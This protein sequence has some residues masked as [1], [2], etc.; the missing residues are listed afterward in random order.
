MPSEVFVPSE[1]AT[2]QE[3]I[4]AVDAGGTVNVAAGLYSPTATIMANKSVSILGP[5]ANVDPRPNCM[6][7]RIPGD[8]ATEAIV[9]GTLFNLAR[10]FRITADDVTING[11]EIRNGTGDLVDAPDAAPTKLRPNV[12]YNIIHGAADEGVQLRRIVEG[13]ISYNHIYDTAGDGINICCSSDNNTISY[14]E[15]HAI[16]STDAG[17]ALYQATNS[18]I[19]YNIL[20]DMTAMVSN[21]GIKLGDDTGVDENLPGGIIR[22]NI[23]Y[24]INEDGIVVIMSDTLVEGNE[25]YDSRGTNGA[26]FLDGQTNNI[27]IINNCIHDNGDGPN[28]TYGIVVGKA[29]NVPTNVRVNGNNIFNNPDGGLF[30]NSMAAPPLDAENNW[31]GSED[32]PNTPGGDTTVGNVDY[33]PWLTEPAAVCNPNISCPVDI[34]VANDPGV[35]SATVSYEVVARSNDCGITEISCN[36]RTETISPPLQTVTLVEEQSFPVGMTEVTCSTTNT[37]GDSATCSFLVIV[38]DTE[39]PTIHCP[40]DI[41]VGV[42]PGDTGTVVTYPDPTVSDNCSVVTHICSPPSGSF[43]PLGVTS[44]TCMAEDSA[45]NMSSCSFDITVIELPPLSLELNL[46]LAKE[47]QV[48]AEVNLEIQVNDTQSDLQGTNSQPSKECIRAQRVYDWV[49][50][51]TESLRTVS[52]PDECI[53]PI[54]NCQNE[55]NEVTSSCKVLPNASTFTILDDVRRVTA[56][57]GFS[58]VPI[59]FSVPIMIRYTCNNRTICEFEVTIDTVDEVEVCYPEGTSIT[60][61]VTAGNCFIIR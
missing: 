17:I 43:F 57:P 10:I 21:D 7:T 59:R 61:I 22:N 12:I 36:G 24:N 50:F 46:T 4:D 19:E 16:R 52:V 45:G 27:T 54:L 9:D 42:P 26:L 53:I 40:E 29:G 56:R 58:T 8:P 28:T 20:Y 34:T 49:V 13:A 38:E 41:L 15:L 14:N 6:T 5:Q 32:G 47:V 31:W 39:S 3:G 18:I 48:V 60:A 55:G 35:C 33:T 23:I 2:I 30:Y 11:F 25:V 44:V 37:S 1:Y 51:C